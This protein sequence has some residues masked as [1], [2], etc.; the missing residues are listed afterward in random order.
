MWKGSGT[1]LG[2]VL[3]SNISSFL[4]F[5]PRKLALPQFSATWSAWSGGPYRL[6]MIL[7]GLPESFCLTCQ[8]FS[9]FKLLSR[10]ALLSAGS[11]GIAN[12]R[13]EFFSPVLTL[14]HFILT[15]CPTLHIILKIIFNGVFVCLLYEVQRLILSNEITGQSYL[16]CQNWT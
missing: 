12:T 5:K 8:H 7:M 16:F 2:P 3:K 11:L 6:F 10:S 13:G 15:S 4:N 1:P 9:E 14:A